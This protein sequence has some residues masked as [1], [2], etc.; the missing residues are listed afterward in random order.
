MPWGTAIYAENP[1]GD[2]YGG[3]LVDSTFD[4]PRWVLDCAGFSY[5]PKD[6][7]WVWE[8]SWTEVD[9]LEVHRVIWD[10]FQELPSGDL[11]VEVD[12]VSSPVRIGT[13]ETM[14]V[15][16]QILRNVYLWESGPVHHVHVD[17]WLWGELQNNGWT[18]GTPDS[19]GELLDPPADSRNGSYRVDAAP[20]DDVVVR[21]VRLRRRHRQA[22]R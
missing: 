10:R 6:Q 1:N 18:I 4:G 17:E 2:L 3:I 19:L 21:H 20:F 14:P 22:R 5:Y 13:P 16:E 11:G 15:W 12:V 9:P 8:D 7:P